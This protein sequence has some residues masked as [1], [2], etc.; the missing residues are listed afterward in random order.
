MGLR[1]VLIWRGEWMGAPDKDP[2]TP[3]PRPDTKP[4][5]G[6]IAPTVQR[7]G[8]GPEGPLR[9]PGRC[10]PSHRQPAPPFP[11]I[12]ALPL[13]KAHF[14]LPL[15]I[16]QLDLDYFLGA[17]GPTLTTPTR[18]SQRIFGPEAPLILSP[19]EGYLQSN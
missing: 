18:V 13:Q 17:N 9:A 12:P 4:T 8:R 16:P 19:R 7:G 3:S 5:K 14:Q 10:A 1:G 15:I 11:G 6:R 2:P